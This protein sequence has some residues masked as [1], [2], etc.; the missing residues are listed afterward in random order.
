[1]HSD[2]G[3]KPQEIGSLDLWSKAVTGGRASKITEQTC[4]SYR[5]EINGNGTV[6]TTGISADT[7]AFCSD[8]L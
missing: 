6:K 3:I 1:M 2:E 8:L 7:V 4:G 5:R